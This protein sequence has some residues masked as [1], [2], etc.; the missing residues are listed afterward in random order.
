MKL[1]HKNPFITQMQ[2]SQVSSI[3]NAFPPK[4]RND[5]YEILCYVLKQPKEILLANPEIILNKKQHK[6]FC[7]CIDRLRAE[8]PL[9][10][11]VGYKYFFDSK[12]IVNKHT[13]IPRPE[14][15]VLVEKA[16]RIIS[17]VARKSLNILEIGTGTGCISV[18]ILKEIK[19]KPSLYPTI[20]IMATDISEEALK[21]A[22]KNAQEILGKSHEINF[23]KADIIPDD[24]N[25]K[26]DLIISNPPY[27]T[28]K[29][30]LDLDSSV[31]KFEPK[32]ALEGGKDGLEVYKKIL[33]RTQ[34]NTTPS[35]RFIFEINP[36]TLGKL[37]ELIRPHYLQTSIEV[38][39]DQ[40]NRN[41]F[42]YFQ[43]Q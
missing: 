12:F 2:N 23:I 27:I 15:E 41:R 29:E 14:T 31:Y 8:E 7:D 43:T 34:T 3:I 25:E 42:L 1:I 10:Y 20:Q 40:Y 13:L 38:I 11:I 4:D 28:K 36:T 16:L 37:E 21:I 24:L 22:E 17:S 26:F 19:K 30:Y 6:L 5:I 33:D 18:S 32:T 9:A 35:G 39:K